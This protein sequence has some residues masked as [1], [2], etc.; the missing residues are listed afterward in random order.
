VLA[1]P[2]ECWPFRKS[3]GRSGRVLAVPEECWPF[4]KSV[5]RYVGQ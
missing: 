3:V 1:V 2:E 4:R 5:G